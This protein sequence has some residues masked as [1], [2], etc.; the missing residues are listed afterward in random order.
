[1]ETSAGDLAVLKRMSE[2]L[3]TIDS[4]RGL[5]RTEHALKS[6]LDGNIE[7]VRSNLIQA[8]E[9]LGYHVT[10]ADPLHAR[11]PARG[12]A[13][14]YLSANILEYP[15][16]LTIGLRE[17]GPGATLAT[18]D[19]ISEHPGGLSFKGDLHTQMREAEAIIAIAG[20]DRNHVSCSSC[21]A[22]QMGEGRFCRVC[23]APTVNRE[24][25]ELEILHITAGSR[26]G[27]HLIASGALL[28]TF[29]LLAA[30][31]ML[32]VGNFPGIGIGVLLFVAVTGLLLLFQG[33][34]ALSRALNGVPDRLTSKDAA[35]IPQPRQNEL[36]PPSVTEGTTSLLTKASSSRELEPVP[37]RGGDTA[38][39][40]N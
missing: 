28:V 31:G 30:L 16:K 38:P 37:V 21:G 22:A 39:L 9:Q 11:R 12:A 34:A 33:I 13:R 18:L 40:D 3:E 2:A 20:A 25:A 19:Y 29:G 4:K 17:I 10:S 7:K 36:S 35:Q 5:T 27:H 32:F 26:S 14:Y 6:V 23:G 8:L 24:L 15:T 1:M